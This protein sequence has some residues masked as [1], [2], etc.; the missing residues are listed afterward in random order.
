MNTSKTEFTKVYIATAEKDQHGNLV[1]GNE[2]WR[3]A[4]LLGSHLCAKFDIQ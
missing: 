1:R 3:K 4:K 2:E